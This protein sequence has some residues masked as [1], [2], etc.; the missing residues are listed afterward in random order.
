M[1][2]KIKEKNKIIFITIWL[3]FLIFLIIQHRFIYMHFDD[4]GYASLSYGYTGNDNGMSWT[5]KDFFSFLVWHY[6]NWGGR[7]LF[8]GIEILALKCGEWCIQLLQA[9]LIWIISWFSYLLVKRKEFDCVAAWI[10]IILYGTICLSAA[11]DGLFWYAA[12]AGYVWPFA[13]FF[14]GLFFMQRMKSKKDIL[15]SAVLF[16]IAG[17]SHEQI[18]VAVIMFIVVCVIIDLFFKKEINIKRITIFVCGILGSLIE[19]CAPGN[20]VRADSGDNLEF[21]QQSFLEKI[22]ETVPIILKINLGPVNWILIVVLMIVLSLICYYIAKHNKKYIIFIVAAINVFVDIAMIIT[23]SCDINGMLADVIRLTFV[24]LCFFQ[25]SYYLLIKGKDCYFALLVGGVCSQGMLVV[26]PAIYYRSVLPFQLIIHVII[27]YILISS[28]LYLKNIVLFIG[29]TIITVPSI[30]NIGYITL[31]YYNNSQINLINRYKL[32]ERS[33][34]IKAGDE[35]NTIILY[36]LVDDR[37]TS[38]MPYQ[39][40]FIEVWVKNYFE[41]PQE[42]EFV[43]QEF[44]KSGT[45][46]DS[47]IRK[48]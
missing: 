4:F 45:C 13:F 9:I 16:F 44:G 18:S 8:Y 46:Y 24:L 47:V 12:S 22:R 23:M 27:A 48:N 36:R 43:W 31:G 29:L 34:Q 19:I 42:I 10:V 14:G 5:L 11:S 20:F 26:S 2:N 21:Y 33:T 15:I 3:V 17:F 38:Q 39:Q 6:N 1:L 40:K 25:F 37:F 28:I 41:I 30:Y 35:I 32:K 7:V